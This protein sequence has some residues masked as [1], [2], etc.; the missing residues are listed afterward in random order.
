VAR[1][2]SG[3]PFT[4]TRGNGALAAA[5][6][7]LGDNQVSRREQKEIWDPKKLAVG[8]SLIARGDIDVAFGIGEGGRECPALQVHVAACAEYLAERG[9]ESHRREQ[10]RG[11]CHRHKLS[12]CFIE[13]SGAKSNPDQ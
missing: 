3:P 10:P 4:Q 5:T 13:I 7:A 11:R 2:F 1:C 9:H 6:E 12:F 8:Q